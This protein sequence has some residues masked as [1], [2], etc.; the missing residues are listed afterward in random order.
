M[1]RIKAQSLVS[2]RLRDVSPSKTS[3]KFP[4]MIFGVDE[5][6]L[7]IWSSAPGNKCCRRAGTT[8]TRHEIH[9]RQYRPQLRDQGEKRMF[10]LCE[11]A[12]PLGFGP[13]YL[14]PPRSPRAL[15]PV[16][17]WHRANPAMSALRFKVGMMIEI[18]LKSLSRRRL[19][20]LLKFW[21]SSFLARC[22]MSITRNIRRAESFLGQADQR[23]F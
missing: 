18:I 23:S 22:R 9:A 13:G 19:F 12:Q 3:R 11:R 4:P 17:G 14:R 15:L 16:A 20:C 5:S 8:I 2:H 10:G 1:N 7:L 21:L 6:T